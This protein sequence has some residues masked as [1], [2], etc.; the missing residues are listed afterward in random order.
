MQEIGST[1]YFLILFLFL[2]VLL[3]AK[4]LRLPM[5]RKQFVDSTVKALLVSYTV[6]ISLV[7]VL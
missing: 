3:P 1:L 4:V 7:Y 6:C 2:M 5:G